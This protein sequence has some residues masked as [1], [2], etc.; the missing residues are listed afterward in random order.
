MIRATS[1]E[2][3]L[4]ILDPSLVEMNWKVFAMPPIP[5]SSSAEIC[6]RSGTAPSSTV[7]RVDADPEVADTR[8]GSCI[9]M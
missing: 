7:L 5:I 6:L 2:I 8:D 9:A 3:Q 4:I 1:S